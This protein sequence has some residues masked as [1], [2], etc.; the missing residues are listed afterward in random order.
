M[1]ERTFDIESKLLGLLRLSESTV[2]GTE[3]E[4][5]LALEMAIRMAAKHGVKLSTLADKRNEY[6][7]TNTWF[8]GGSSTAPANDNYVA[9]EL[10]KVARWC[11][12]AESLGWSRYRRSHNQR[13]GTIYAYR[14]E[15]RTPKLE[16]RIFDRPWGDVEFEVI[17]NPDPILGAYEAWMENIFDVVCLGVTFEDFRAWVNTTRMVALNT[18]A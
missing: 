17:K 5:K 14:Q 10:V 11:A 8:R 7:A 9:P 2:S 13:E 1:N 3:N 15:G 12:Y 6:A 18:S 4:A 16:L